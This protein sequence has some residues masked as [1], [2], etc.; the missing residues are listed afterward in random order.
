MKKN[1]RNKWSGAFLHRGRRSLSPH[2]KRRRLY[3]FQR[4]AHA[5]VTARGTGDFLSKQT[6]MGIS[7]GEG[8]LY[9]HKQPGANTDSP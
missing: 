7:S 2:K 3:F 1:K 9:R 6:A 5:Q 8:Y 4:N